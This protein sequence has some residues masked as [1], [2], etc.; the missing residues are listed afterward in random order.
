MP[1]GSSTNWKLKRGDGLGPALGGGPGA[2]GMPDRV[3]CL[4]VHV[5]HELATGDNPI[6]RI[7]LERILPMA[8]P[9]PCV[10][11]VAPDGA[12]GAPA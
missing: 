12:E 9:E 3:K 10:A 8:C 5:A 4:H 2:G 11:S 7:A 1:S 6:G